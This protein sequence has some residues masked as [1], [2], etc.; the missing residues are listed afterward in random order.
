MINLKAILVSSTL[1]NNYTIKQKF[2]FK[3]VTVKDIENFIKNILNNKVTVSEIPL[4]V[5]TLFRK[6]GQK[7]PPISFSSVTSAK[8]RISPKNFLAF[9]FNHFA[10][11]V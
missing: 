7:G 9:S 11:L 4:N 6:V 8:V 1:K 3:P 10:T 5:L 2:T